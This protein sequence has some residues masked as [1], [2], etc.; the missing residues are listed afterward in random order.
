MSLRSVAITSSGLNQ[1]NPTADVI[2]R[3]LQ[4]LANSLEELSLIEPAP[5]SRGQPDAAPAERGVFDSLVVNLS[6][7]E[8]LKIHPSGVSDL[9]LLAG[10]PKLTELNV[11]AT[12]VRAGQEITQD[13]V[14]NLLKSSGSLK[15]FV[16]DVQQV[17]AWDGEWWAEVDQVAEERGVEL[18]LSE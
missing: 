6:S 13:E 12:T 17:T 1:E 7:A 15:R 4:P 10:L 16:I 2:R 18:E 9:S 14:E 3:H 5:S 8:R 11:Q